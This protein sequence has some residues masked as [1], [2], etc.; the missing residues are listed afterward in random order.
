MCRYVSSMEKAMFQG[1]LL[2]IHFLP[3]LPQ[4][5][6]GEGQAG[7]MPTAVLCLLL[8]RSAA[9][10]VSFP[11]T[12]CAAVLL[13]HLSASLLAIVITVVVNFSAVRTSH[14]A[15]IVIFTLMYL[16]W[17]PSAVAVGVNVTVFALF[18]YCPSVLFCVAVAAVIAV[19]AFSLLVVLCWLLLGWC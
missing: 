8:C 13:L 7:Y 6:C 17:M 2:R 15:V 19:V 14:V 5:E 11:C 12:A 16:Q 3:L 10:V 1:Y 4:Y 18:A 9:V